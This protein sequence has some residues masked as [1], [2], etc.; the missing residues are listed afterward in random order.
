MSKRSE[1][2]KQKKSPK[3]KRRAGPLVITHYICKDPSKKF[4]SWP[5]MS[6][7]KTVDCVP[8]I[9]SLGT[10]FDFFFFFLKHKAPFLTYVGFC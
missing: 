9:P 3:I 8:F 2:F 5:F 4:T 6:K 7:H 1:K 10:V